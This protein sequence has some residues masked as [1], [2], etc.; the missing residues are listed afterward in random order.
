V[1]LPSPD[2]ILIDAGR[3][4]R[5]HGKA[6][7][8]QIVR[9][10]GSTPG[11]VGW[12]LV[13]APDGKC[14]GNLGGGAFEALVTADAR[15][16]LGEAG[17]RPELKRYYLTEEAV[18]GEPTGM[19]CGGLADVLLEVVTLKPQLVICG[20]GPVGQAVAANAE[21]CGFELMVVED[22]EEFRQPELFPEGTRFSEVTRD[23]R[24]PFLADVRGR[25]FVVVVTRCWETD[26]AALASTLRQEPVELAYLGVMGSK[27]KVE[28]IRAELDEQGF[29]LE[30]V[31]LRGPIGLAIGGETP[32]EIAVSILAEL[33]R[34]RSGEGARTPASAVTAE[35][36]LEGG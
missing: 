18:K 1:R 36:A 23:Y 2:E 30:A 13:V 20:G 33:I 22:R 9:T 31:D 21:L 26:L 17:S 11:K 14:R 35:P 29:D 34:V 16:K 24:Q 5:R 15:L 25:L 12:K 6:A 10:E 27:R 3:A 32:G 19:V 8:C 28:R 7:L 4:A